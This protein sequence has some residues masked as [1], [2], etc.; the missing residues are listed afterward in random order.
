MSGQPPFGRTNPDGTAF[1]NTRE[2][3][4]AR[5]WPVEVLQAARQR[6]LRDFTPEE[7]KRFEIDPPQAR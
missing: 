1:V 4:N 2:E 7:R 6:A 5:L 3:Y